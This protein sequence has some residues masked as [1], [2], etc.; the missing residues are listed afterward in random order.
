MRYLGEYRVVIDWD[1][2]HGLLKGSV[3]GDNW[4]NHS[5]QSASWLDGLWRGT[6]M[7]DNDRERIKGM[8]MGIF[9][10]YLRRYFFWISWG[11]M[12]FESF[13]DDWG[14]FEEMIEGTPAPPRWALTGL[15]RNWGW[16]ALRASFLGMVFRFMIFFDDGL[17]FSGVSKN[18][19][20]EAGLKKFIRKFFWTF[21]INF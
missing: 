14:I 11:M 3:L 12:V 18:F 21:G 15:S 4:M 13:C 8:T 20:W 5:A 2:W 10:G 19:F 9:E 17:D 1:P 6:L 7:G 16:C